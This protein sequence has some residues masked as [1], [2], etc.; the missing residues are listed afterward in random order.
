VSTLSIESPGSDDWIPRNVLHAAIAAIVPFFALAIAA[1]ITPAWAT[2]PEVLHAGLAYGAI[3]LSFVCG[4]RWGVAISQ[5]SPERLM[6][7]VLALWGWLAL[8][9][10]PLLGLCLLIAGYF[11]Q[12]LWNVL[13]TDRGSV[14]A[15]FGKLSSLYTVGAVIALLA[16]LVRLLT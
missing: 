15:W 4:A 16:M 14:P 5:R 13:A 3:A 6:M 8:V 1:W 11:L 12:A 2:A 7:A 9:I 10:P